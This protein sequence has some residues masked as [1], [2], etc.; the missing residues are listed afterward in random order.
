M[1]N[2]KVRCVC[3]RHS[4][5]SGTMAML[6]KEWDCILSQWEKYPPQLPL[7]QQDL[8][9]FRQSLLQLYSSPSTGAGGG[10]IA[11]RS[12]PQFTAI[13]PH[14]FSNASF[15]KFHSS[16][17]ENSCPPFAVTRHTV[18]VCVL[19]CP[20]CH[21][22]GRTLVCFCVPKGNG[23]HMWGQF[24]DKLVLHTSSSGGR[25]ALHHLLKTVSF[26]WFSW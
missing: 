8:K 13:L 7:S 25:P 9:A 24:R 12:L 17:E 1:A 6:L 5:L 11:V 19:I 20:A 10:G 14:F 4:A 22:C 23:R 2:W 3:K 15:Q 21:L 26:S 16:P 18:R